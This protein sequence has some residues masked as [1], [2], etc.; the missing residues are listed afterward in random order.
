[1]KKLEN[2]YKEE[3]GKNAYDTSNECEGVNT[4]TYYTQYVEW[5]E[6]KLVNKNDLLPLV[7]GR[8]YSDVEIEELATQAYADGCSDTKKG[9]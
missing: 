8:Y 1:M 5:L 3:T 6:Q 7:V 2:Q 9:L 4:G